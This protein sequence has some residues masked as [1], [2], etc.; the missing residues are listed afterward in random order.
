MDPGPTVLACPFIL[1]SARDQQHGPVRATRTGSRSRAT[2]ESRTRTFCSDAGQNRAEQAAGGDAPAGATS[3][4]LAGRRGGGHLGQNL[5]DHRLWRRLLH[6]GG[7]VRGGGAEDQEGGAS[8]RCVF[9][10]LRVCERGARR[11]CLSVACVLF[12]APV[13]EPDYLLCDDCQKPFMDSYLSNSF[14]LSVC[15]KCRYA[16]THT[17]TRMGTNTQTLSG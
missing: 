2:A 1:G 17:H 5:Q 15:D 10:C 14:D 3:E 8:A 13:I 12:A 7:G 6:R 11:A 16:R 9:A 4:P